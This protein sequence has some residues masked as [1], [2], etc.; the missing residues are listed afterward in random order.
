[1]SLTTKDRVLNLLGGLGADIDPEAIQQFIEDAEGYVQEYTGETYSFE[2][3]DSGITSKNKL[4]RKVVGELAA[5]QAVK[6][7]HSGSGKDYSLGDLTVNSASTYAA[8]E[9]SLSNNIKESLK[10]LGR[11]TK[12]KQTFYS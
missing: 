12:W 6:S 3:E 9:T 10:L 2:P 8:Q 5:L 4:V 11:K 7:K 1:M